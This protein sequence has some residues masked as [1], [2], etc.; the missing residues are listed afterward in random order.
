VSKPTTRAELQRQIEAMQASINGLP[1][2]KTLAVCSDNFLPC[3]ALERRTDLHELDR[4]RD[5]VKRGLVHQLV[6]TLIHSG[7]VEFQEHLEEDYRRFGKSLRVT[8]RLK[9]A[10]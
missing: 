7:A 5:H 10:A 1:E 8:A 9:I 2:H 6:D 3:S 4:Y